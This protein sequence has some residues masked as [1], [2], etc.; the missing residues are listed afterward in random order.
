MQLKCVNQSQVPCSCCVWL[1]L[2]VT[3]RLHESCSSSASRRAS[4]RLCLSSSSCRLSASSRSFAS[5]A[6]NSDRISPCKKYCN[7]VCDVDP[8]MHY[9]KL[10]G[11]RRKQSPR[12]LE[13][14]DQFITKIL[15]FKTNIFRI[16]LYRIRSFISEFGSWSALQE[17]C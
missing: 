2:C 15:A 10:L 12:S 6:S 3:A 5:S 16:F 17:V 8:G 4:S 13:I 14:V 11:S 1:F 9:W 7:L